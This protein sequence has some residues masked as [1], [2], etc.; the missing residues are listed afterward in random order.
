MKSTKTLR[1]VT[2]A[3]RVHLFGAI[4]R[5]VVTV[6]SRALWQLAGHTLVDGKR[7]TMEV[8]P[9]L[10]IGFFARPPADGAP[11]AIVLLLGDDAR[12]PV[13]VAVR[14]EATR[15]AIVGALEAGETAVYSASSLVHLK[16]DGT[17]EAR[18]AGGV[19]VPLATKA[20]VQDLRDWVAAHVHPANGSPPSGPAP[21]NPTGTTKLKGE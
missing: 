2:D 11:E 5:M 6:S 18:S 19:A 4:R 8:E 13:A 3:A 7:E 16:A 12:A 15:R 20:D 9:F 10:G 1:Q 21:A 14:D 17:I